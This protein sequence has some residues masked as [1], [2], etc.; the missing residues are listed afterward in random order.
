MNP[1]PKS[2]A[3]RVI[4]IYTKMGEEGAMDFIDGFAES[5]DKLRVG[6]GTEEDLINIGFACEYT[7]L[8]C[9]KVGYEAS[10]QIQRALDATNWADNKH[11][12]RGR[13]KPVI[14]QGT[15]LTAVDD[16]LNFLYT[17]VKQS[18]VAQL[19]DINDAM[20]KHIGLYHEVDKRKMQ[21]SLGISEHG[22][23]PFLLK[24]LPSNLSLAEKKRMVNAL[25]SEGKL[26]IA[27]QAQKLGKTLTYY[28]IAE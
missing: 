26:K 14:Y 12:E 19:G 15:G 9:E 7:K 21:I 5:F 4:D 17:A 1:K 25:I 20:A 18:S 8:L 11:K 2:T 3:M 27:Q 28:Q 22:K 10:D 13:D 24:K 23:Q 6:Q 16:M